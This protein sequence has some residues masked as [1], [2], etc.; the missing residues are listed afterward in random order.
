MSRQLH[1]RLDVDLGDSRLPDRFWAKVDE[2]ANGC[3]RWTGCVNVKGY[4]KFG[5]GRR[6][7]QAHRVSYAAFVGPIPDGLDVDHLCRVRNCVNPA[8]LEAVTHTLNVQRR[9]Q[10][11]PR[12]T[13]CHR[14][15]PFDEENILW[16]G[17]T[18]NCRTCR[19]NTDRERKR[20]MAQTPG[21]REHKNQR[22]RELYA[23]RKASA[24]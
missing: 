17:N 8:H 21:W 18:R 15:H 20:R 24:A 23:Q 2:D 11:T 13:H 16:I 6:C 12:A 5:I 14:G 9:W 10:V 19:R 22:R 7:Y 3:W 1:V 4:G